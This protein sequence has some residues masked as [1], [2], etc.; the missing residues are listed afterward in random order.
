[1]SALWRNIFKY[2]RKGT[3]PV[4]EIIREV[5]LFEGLSSRELQLVERIL[6]D[7]TYR[8]GEPVFHKGDPGVGMYII[9]SGTVDITDV[10]KAVKPLAELKEGDFFGDL[11]LLDD[12][13]RSASAIARTECRLLCIF[14]PDLMDL[15]NRLPRLGVKILLRLATTTG[16]RL[17]KTNE[18][19][20]ALSGEEHA[21]SPRD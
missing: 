10:A 18:Y 12:A 16:E 19:L 21:E 2:R 5:P 13:P 7:R 14:R 9:V 17:R 8:A 15:I 3:L 6:H 4:R 20:S 1:M 11:S